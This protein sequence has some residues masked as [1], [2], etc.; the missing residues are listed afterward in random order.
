MDCDYNTANEEVFEARAEHVMWSK[1]FGGGI[2]TVDADHD[3]T[4]IRHVREIQCDCHFSTGLSVHPGTS[5]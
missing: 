3:L 4:I 2:G 1:I 5:M